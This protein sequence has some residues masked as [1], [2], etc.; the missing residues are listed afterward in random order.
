MGVLPGVGGNG[1]VVAQR[2]EGRAVRAGCL[3]QVSPPSCR[4][5]ATRPRR[6]SRLLPLCCS[7][8]PCLPHTHLAHAPPPTTGKPHSGPTPALACARRPHLP[9]QLPPTAGHRQAR[10]AAAARRL[11]RQGSRP[12]GPAAEPAGAARQHA[13]AAGGAG[14]G[15]PQRRGAG[16]VGGAAAGEGCTEHSGTESYKWWQPAHAGGGCGM[17]GSTAAG[18][19]PSTTR[20]CLRG[21]A[22]PLVHVNGTA[23]PPCRPTSWT[24]ST[25]RPRRRWSAISPPPTPTST[26]WPPR[27]P[28]CAT[29]TARGWPPARSACAACRRRTRT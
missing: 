1:V 7:V 27:W 10:P 16:G 25:V 15:E 21:T 28:S 12:G 17:G 29:P 22:A 5:S 4:P 14:G 24:G 20:R 3:L 18:R 8:P 19:L 13:G 6:C 11:Q 23:R 9:P 26:C 2:A